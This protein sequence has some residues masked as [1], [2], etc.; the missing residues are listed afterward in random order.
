MDPSKTLTDNIDEFK[1]TVSEFKSLEDKLS[2]E[3]EVYVLLNSL[4]KAYKV[5]LWSV[6]TREKVE[7]QVFKDS[8]VVLVGE[9]RLTFG[10]KGCLTS[11]KKG[12]RLYPNKTSYLK[13]LSI[14]CLSVNIVC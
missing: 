5:T 9:K 7:F 14:S 11:A 8:R 4:P 10:T 2:D 6:N 13:K 1:K 12:L 3:N